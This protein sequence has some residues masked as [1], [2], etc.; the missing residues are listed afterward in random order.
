MIDFLFFSIFFLWVINIAA[1]ILKL[2]YIIQLKEYRWDRILDFLKSPEGRRSIFTPF[3][4]VYLLIILLVFFI[5]VFS[6]TSLISPFV[7]L[8][9]VFLF[10][11]AGFFIILKKLRDHS[12]LR[13]RWT[14]KSFL[15]VSLSFLMMLFV[16]LIFIL[17]FIF[18][19]MNSD[20]FIYSF[21][22]IS[23]LLF[24]DTFLMIRNLFDL[25]YRGWILSLMSPF[26]FIY[27][28]FVP[29]FVL[30]WFLILQAGTIF[31]KKYM[32]W[33]AAKKITSMSHLT[34]IGI[35]GS[36]G[37][38]TTKEFLT[39]I[40]SKKFQVLATPANVNSEIGV[41]QIIL[42]KLTPTHDIFIVEMGAYKKG[43]IALISK[44]TQPKIGIMTAINEQHISL[45]GSIEN[46]KQ[47]KYE[48]MESL[49]D[50]GLALFNGDNDYC[51][52]L[53]KKT[54]KPKLLYSVQ[55]TDD[56]RVDKDFSH[57][58][59]V[60][61][62]KKQ[63]SDI[64]ATNVKGTQDG[65]RC[66]L[67]KKPLK[68]LVSLQNCSS[69]GTSEKHHFGNE[70]EQQDFFVPV[71]GI[72]NVSNLLAAAATA[73]YF[74]MSLAE[75]SE[76]AKHIQPREK[77]LK[78]MA[79][80]RNTLIID[81]SYSA[82]PDGV[83][84]ALEY[85]DSLAA[86]KKIMIMRGMIELGEKSAEAHKRVGKKAAEVCDLVIFTTTDFFSDFLAGAMEIIN[87]S[88]I[89]YSHVSHPAVSHSKISHPENPYSENGKG[90]SEKRNFGNEN[91]GFFNDAA[92][93]NHNEKVLQISSAEE[94][95]EKVNPYVSDGNIF[96]LENR[97]PSQIILA[98]KMLH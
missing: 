43:E 48:L 86:P 62:A 6:W 10:Y 19:Q 80:I 81:D 95:M 18:A 60:D 29:F 27:N 42:K 9:N 47:A 82:N 90:T 15:F 30:F 33:R 89:S 75:I 46:I 38:S 12:L 97:I 74:G 57:G 13:P 39:T 85:L 24:L 68:N 92:F 44:M 2:T 93:F 8:T 4:F 1:Q 7:F 83:M 34:V 53:Y 77:T 20:F 69:K 41:A 72:H 17:V 66:T 73:S 63:S 96:L 71:P 36:Y 45:F 32:Y 25:L 35:T 49:P 98:L 91:V 52:E 58:K 55:K 37:K 22:F 56:E 40:L 16:P 3:F 94:I 50:D 64:S 70:N 88:E 51:V 87:R 28:L 5:I 76:A 67:H 65:I 59:N 61:S 23:R 84:A 11:S 26:L 79:G 54:K 78:L 21:Y 31:I 14:K